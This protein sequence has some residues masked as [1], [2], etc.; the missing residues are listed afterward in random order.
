ML[1]RQLIAFVRVRLTFPVLTGLWTHSSPILAFL[2][3]FSPENAIAARFPGLRRLPLDIASFQN[4]SFI[5]LRIQN[6][7]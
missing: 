3:F 6:V 1:R 7:L 2:S 4:H 5:S